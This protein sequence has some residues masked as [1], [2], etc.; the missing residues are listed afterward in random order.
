[1]LHCQSQRQVFGALQT[2][3]RTLDME[4]SMP[5]ASE[6]IEFRSSLSARPS[7]RKSADAITELR[8]T[9]A[10]RSLTE[11]SAAFHAA[12]AAVDRHLCRCLSEMAI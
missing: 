6:L 8:A 4:H 10:G 7:P 12:Q 11:A 3:A 1:M 9:R 5:S 2:S